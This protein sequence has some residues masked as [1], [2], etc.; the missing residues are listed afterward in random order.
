MADFT[1]YQALGNDYLVVDARR[2][3][4]GP[5]LARA[6]CDRHYGV[7]ADGVLFGSQPAG[8]GPIPLQI[9]NSDGTPCDRS[10]NGIRMYALQLAEQ[11]PGRTE[12]IVRTAAGDTAVRLLGSGR[13]SAELGRPRFEAD[14][15]PGLELAGAAL[16]YQLDLAG[17]T[18]QVTCVDNGNPHAVV[19]VDELDAERARRLGPLIA[20]HP[21]FPERRNVEFVR[22]IDRAWIELEIV[23]RGAGYT[24]ASGSGACAA[25]SAARRHGLVGDRVRV[26]MPGGELEVSFDGEQVSL[27]GPVEKVA[28]GQFSAALR[29]R[30]DAMLG[31]KPVSTNPAEE[32]YPM[33]RWVFEDSVGRYD[34]DLGDSHVQCRR[35]GEFDW[36]AELELNYGHDRGSPALREL[37]AQRYAGDPERV[38]VTHGAQEALYL[39]YCTLLRP[40][41]RV[42]AFQPGW[43]QAWQAPAELGAEVVQLDLVGDFG[44]DLPSISAAA[45]SGVRLI[46]LSTPCN[47]TGRRLREPEL[48]ALLD[49][50]RRYDGHLLLDEEYA[51]DLGRSP[52][53]RDDRVVSVSSLSKIAGL[54]GLRVGWLYGAPAIARAAAEYKHLTTIST[55]V[56][57]ETLAM[58][59]LSNWD[60]YQRDYH[61]LTGP[62]LRLLE[63]FCDR[64][65]DLLRL[66][67][68]EGTPFAWVQLAPGLSSMAI[69]RAV[70]ESGVLIMPGEVLGRPGGLRICF[71]RDTN[72]LAE[73]LARMDAVLAELIPEERFAIR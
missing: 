48:V 30:L 62:G 21:R 15:P 45:G 55:S 49:L 66:T 35:V 33:R 10:A 37:I 64:H 56:L 25:A 60:R 12:F 18:V 69:A 68:P 24:L 17:E 50:V 1:K 3:P 67:P 47:P 20:S 13:V 31:S 23:E 44:L 46:T 4:A 34:I 51:L 71:A 43:Q 40:G 14:G 9:R 52:A 29:S 58:Q 7:G 16:R 53:L 22:V 36:P 5:E 61:A 59:V 42:L 63:E 8:T 70:L 73:G 6:L 11:Q 39:L 65:R 57:S 38:V 2:W 28:S 72:T 41:D 27:A 54:P 19:F 26:S 32:L